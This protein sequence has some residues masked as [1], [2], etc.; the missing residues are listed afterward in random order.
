ML[1]AVV[2][3]KSRC[4]YVGSIVLSS[5]ACTGYKPCSPQLVSDRILH[6]TAAYDE[7]LKLANERQSR[8]KEA[9]RMWQFYDDVEDE[10]AWIK[11]KE[12]IM[13]SPDLGH[14]LTSI[15]LLL[16]KHK[17]SYLVHFY[18]YEI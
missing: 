14:D 2:F 17:V 16:T 15:R 6:L 8:L 10:E 3:I 4:H 7:L 13:S 5:C 11:E 1:T 12:Q 9:R 18:A